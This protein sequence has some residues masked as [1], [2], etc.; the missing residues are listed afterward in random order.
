[1]LRTIKECS[2]N[3]DT[4]FSVNQYRSVKIAIELIVSMGII[5]CLLPG[6]GIDMAKLCPRAKELP[7]EELTDMQVRLCI[8]YYAINLILYN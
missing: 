8:N 5:P 3:T 1:M 2:V 4:F 6:V 7:Q